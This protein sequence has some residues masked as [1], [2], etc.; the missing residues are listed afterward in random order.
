MQEQY[1]IISAQVYTTPAAWVKSAHIQS[2]NKKTSKCPIFLH[3]FG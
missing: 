1:C 2:D 3:F